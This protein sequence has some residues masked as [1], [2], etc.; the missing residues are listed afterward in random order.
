RPPPLPAGL[1]RA[2]PLLAAGG[3]AA[4]RVADLP[5]ATR[6][7]LLDGAAPALPAT[8]NGLSRPELCL[9]AM[10]CSWPEAGRLC[11]VD[12]GTRR[13]G[14][15]AGPVLVLA[16]PA[17]FTLPGRPAGGHVRLDGRLYHDRSR[18][19]PLPLAT[20]WGDERQLR[21]WP[22]TLVT[23]RRAVAPGYERP[24]L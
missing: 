2:V 12:V 16:G 11:P 21:G 22:R 18:R 6:R 14:N 7:R 15:D 4:G 3:A 24:R 5:A 20:S 17:D 10:A 13:S 23:R 19:M 9:A 1:G 8:H